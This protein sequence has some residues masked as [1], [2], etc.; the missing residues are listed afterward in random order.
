MFSPTRT[1]YLVSLIIHGSILLAIGFISFQDIRK[2][3]TTVE[4]DFTLTGN[5]LP[6]GGQAALSG[7]PAPVRSSPSR[8]PISSFS[9]SKQNEPSR[10]IPADGN[11]SVAGAEDQAATPGGEGIQTGPSYPGAGGGN[12]RNLNYLGSGG[13]DERNFSFV[14]ETILHSIR[15]P[16]RARRMGWEGKVILSFTVIENG[17]ILDV[18]IVQGSGFS[19]LDENARDTVTRINLKRKIPFRL[20]V[21]LPVEYRLH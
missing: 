17:D 19:L 5:E 10:Y 9:E 18:K 11:A 21:L 16:E 12:A 7:V 2:H 13:T 1:G 20:Y 4:L 8:T 15:Y 14:R 6:R 3:I